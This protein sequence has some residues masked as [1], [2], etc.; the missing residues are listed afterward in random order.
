MKIFLFLFFCF[1][2]LPNTNC[3]LKYT[4]IRKK[5]NNTNET[6]MNYTTIKKTKNVTKK[7]IFTD[8]HMKRALSLF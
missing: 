4:V 3:F 6:V 7:I 5:I 8:E 2:F 1:Y